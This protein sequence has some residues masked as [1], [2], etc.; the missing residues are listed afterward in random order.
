MLVTMVPV[1]IMLSSLLYTSVSDI[2]ADLRGLKKLGYDFS[3][4][5]DIKSVVI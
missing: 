5:L 4:E 2:V 3:K 1:R